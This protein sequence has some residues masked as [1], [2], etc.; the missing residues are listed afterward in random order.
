MKTFEK[1]FIKNQ[2]AMEY[3]MTY[4]WSILI[5]AVVLGALSFLGVFNPL[6]FAPKA[7]AGGCQVIRNT[8]L[9]VSNLEGACNN[10]LPQYVAQF[11]G[12]ASII[13]NNPRFESKTQ[14]TAV[15][16]F[17]LSD[18]DGGWEVH[19]L[20]YGNET[21]TGNAFTMG[22]G[23][24][25]SPYGMYVDTWCTQIS[26]SV[27]P[28]NNIWY[29]GI[30]EIN[31][32]SERVCLDGGSLQCATKSIIPNVITNTPIY[33]GSWPNRPGFAG[34][35]SDAQLYNTSFTN[36]SIE[37]LYQEGVGGVP[38]DSRNLV[39]WWPLNGNANDYSGNQNNGV[40][41]NVVFTSDWYNGYT[42]P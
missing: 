11:N 23:G 6:T 29:M 31:S 14:A 19:F 22:V 8:G 13:I 5:V 36:S 37:A 1:S 35:L 17:R 16:W 24:S 3:L 7:S 34:M 42:Q 4:G 33:M 10:Q 9:G 30:A 12:N 2:S 27:V 26:T 21:C 25:A 39:G 18:P 20:S 40:P 32:T 28:S 15:I 41:T 38:V